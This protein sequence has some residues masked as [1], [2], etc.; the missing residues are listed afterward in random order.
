MFQS[1][2]LSTRP[3]PLHVG[4]IMDGNGRWAELRGLPRSAGH[5]AGGAAVRR[6]VAAAA[7]HGIGVLTL[8][9]LSSGNWQRPPGE[10]RHLLRLFGTYLR[11]EADRCVEEGIRV[12]VIGRRERLPRSLVTEIDL[13]EARTRAGQG[14]HLRL[15]VDYSSR[16][17]IVDAVLNAATHAIRH[18]DET[19][20]ETRAH[21]RFGRLGALLSHVEPDGG[22]LQNVD[23]VIRTGGEQRL[24]DFLLWESAWAEL[25]FMSCA[26][27]DFDE[28]HLAAALLEFHGRERRFGGLPEIRTL[29]AGEG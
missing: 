7:G 18:P 11:S 26:W 4:I 16:D 14:L 2:F 19:P 3:A 21:G 13:V 22:P 12:S 10:V 8:Y 9:A 29:A 6:T 17:A 23:L 27:P 1:T 5:R 25:V 20:G 24:S 28:S 15:A